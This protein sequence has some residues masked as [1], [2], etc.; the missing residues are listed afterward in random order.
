[1]TDELTTTGFV[2]LAQIAREP[3]SPY[4]L[5]QLMRRNVHYL[6]P[7][8]ESRIY[9]EVNRLEAAGFLTAEKAAVGQRTRSILHITAAGRAAV[10]RRLGRPI[11]AGIALHSEA[12]LRVFFATLGSVD[13]LRTALEQVRAEAEELLEVGRGVGEQY[14]AGAGSAPEQA[15]VR[16]M[17]HELL[18]G[19]GR[20]LSGWSAQNLKKVA[21]W[22]DLEGADKRRAAMA[23]FSRTLRG[24]R[25]D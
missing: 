17:V 11:E 6:W 21:R 2:L 7:R 16:A 13:D 1:M 15:H 8:A 14:L 18:I 19:Y 9:G 22:N 5:T 12:L 4:Q 20:L 23:Q 25:Q 3:I 10:D 24:P